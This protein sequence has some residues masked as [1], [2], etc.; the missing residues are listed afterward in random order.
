MFLSVENL[1][2]TKLLAGRPKD[3]EDV[4][5]LLVRHDRTLEHARVEALLS[6]LELALGH[7]DLPPLYRRLRSRSTE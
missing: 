7:S 4:R 1:I 2:V 6:E 3:L 5:E